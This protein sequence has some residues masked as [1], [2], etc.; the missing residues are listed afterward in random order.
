MNKPGKA[1]DLVSVEL[2]DLAAMLD[3]VIERGLIPDEDTNEVCLALSA[4]KD[5][6]VAW[7]RKYH[8]EVSER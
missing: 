5:A 7:R 6:A 2:L 8:A 1:A 4:I 3:D